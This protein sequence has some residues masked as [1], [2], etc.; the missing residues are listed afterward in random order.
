MPGACVGKLILEQRRARS[1]PRLYP[2]LLP[3]LSDPRRRVTWQPCDNPMTHRVANMHLVSAHAPDYFI[4]PL[5]TGHSSVAAHGARSGQPAESSIEWLFAR[6]A[7]TDEFNM[8]ER[9]FEPLTRQHSEHV[10]VSSAAAGRTSSQLPKDT[11]RTEI[12]L[13]G[14][15]KVQNNSIVSTNAPDFFKSPFE[16]A[17]AS[18]QLEGRRQRLSMPYSTALMDAGERDAFSRGKRSTIV[19]PNGK[20]GVSQSRVSLAA[21]DFMQSGDVLV[22]G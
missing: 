19:L 5:T 12:V 2:P 7:R 1:L 18:C 21:P 17:A 11:K 15:R 20:V 6:R 16:N 4:A 14:S 13:A 8:G 22:F 10:L 3:A 9:Q